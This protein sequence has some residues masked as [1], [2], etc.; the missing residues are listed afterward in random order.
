MCKGINYRENHNERMMKHAE[1]FGESY[2]SYDDVNTIVAKYVDERNP[3]G[4]AYETL[5]ECSEACVPIY[6]VFHRNIFRR[7]DGYEMESH[8][9]IWIMEAGNGEESK[10]SKEEFEKLCRYNNC[11]ALNQ[12]LYSS[13]TDLLMAALQDRFGMVGTSML[14]FYKR[15]TYPVIEGDGYLRGFRSSSPQDTIIFSLLYSVFIYMCSA[16][17]LMTK[18]IYELEY[19]NEVSF[20][21]YPRLK[22]HGILYKR[23]YPFVK[24]FDGLT[25]FAN[26]EP[27]DE[28]QEIRNRI[29]HNGGFDYSPWIYNVDIDENNGENI[30]Y[31]PDMKDGHLEK[32]L[33]RCSFYS[34]C[35]KA[36][37]MLVEYVNDFAVCSFETLYRIKS[38]YDVYDSSNKDLISRYLSILSRKISKTLLKTNS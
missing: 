37:K 38:L 13:D 15:M 10:C 20:K 35:N 26:F 12:L 9:P 34:Q 36:N 6:D 23:A 7:L 30:I 24:K 5:E 17:D 25:I 22:S 27:L 1:K 8:M 19:I 32:H 16:M 21:R 2:S 11:V 3:I 14:E 18:V 29:V 33:N 31:L 28:I 4:I